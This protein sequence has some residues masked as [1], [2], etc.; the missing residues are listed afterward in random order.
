MVVLQSVL[1]KGAIMSDVV[2]VARNDETSRYEIHVGDTL[3]G[4][5]EFSVKPETVLVF[6]HTEVFPEFGG[7]GLAGEL[8][9]FAMTDVAA[10]NESVLPLCP[11][12][13]KYLE[14]HDVPGLTVVQRNKP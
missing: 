6:P 10:R 9:R 14:T 8:V 13:V 4:F 2:S 12:V 11:F 1:L 7:R 3:A 5:T